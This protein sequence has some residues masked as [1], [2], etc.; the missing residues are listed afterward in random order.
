MRHTKMVLV[1]GWCL[2]LFAILFVGITLVVNALAQAQTMLYNLEKHQLFE[3]TAGTPTI[4]FLLSFYAV[5]PLLLIPGSVGA[6]YL[7]NEKHGANM[8]VGMYFATLGAFAL[9]LS[10]LMIP[11]LNWHLTTYIPTL[12]QEL[13]AAMVIILQ[14]VHSYFGI[15][16][17]DLLGLGC[18]FVW[19]LITSFVILH[20]NSLPRAVGIIQLIITVLAIFILCLRD[21]GLLPSIY[22]NIQV[23]G[24]M[25]LWIFIF[26][27][28][29][30]SL[31][32]D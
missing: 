31:H 27:I 25:D 23:A 28:S 2:V 22:N 17:G 26:G 32:K 4:R 3:V 29:M 13:Q 15:F 7:F 24:L 9:S 21:S 10:L 19:F 16:I 1:G 20:D 8:R 30:I 14:A 5:L 11:S 6:F 18:L 12:P